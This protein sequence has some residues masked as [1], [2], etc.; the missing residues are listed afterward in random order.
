MKYPIGIQDFEKIIQDGYVYVDKTDL[1]YKLANEGHIYFLSRPRRFG[2]SL[3]ISTLK[4]YFQGRKDLFKGLAIDKLETKWAEYPVFH[5][6]FANGN[7]TEGKA[8]RQILEDYIAEIETVYGKNPNANTIGGRFA[9][10][11]KAAHKKT[12]RRAVVLIDEYDKP[13]LDVIDLDLKVTDSEG[14]RMRLE[15]Y[16][17]NLLKGFYSLFKDAD[18]DLQFVMLT[19]VTKF[20]QVSVFSGFNQPE[21]ISMSGDFEGLCGITKDELLSVFDEPI[22]ALADKFKIS[23]DETVERLKKKYDGYHFGEEMIDI[24]NPFSILNCL[25]S[26]RMH[27]F[28]FASGTPTYLVRLLAHS[29]ENINELV[30]K[31]YDASQFIDYKADIEQ[32]LPMIYQSGYL[33]I[34]DWN[35]D[36][37]TY[38]LDFPNEEV[39]N[40]FIETLASR[41][42]SESSQPKSWVND[43]TDAL[44]NGDTARFEKLMTALLSSTTYRF[45]RKQ[46]AMECE[47]YFQYTFYLIVKMLGFYSTVAEKETSEGRIDCV[48]ECPGYVYII[49]FKLNGSAEA[50]LKQI[51]EKGY[52][53]PYAADSRKL[54]AIGFNFSSEKGTIDGFLTKEL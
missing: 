44:D 23:Y 46:D 27:N 30:G 43:V 54:I 22:H 25:K 35:I 49:E 14:N 3:L 16:N 28:W 1:V 32:P 18:E 48:V 8:L 15:D 36:R 47:R 50:A 19:G 4:Y 6:S 34:K 17:R 29:N 45:Q 9:S 31:Y 20:S 51:E 2:K 38:L 52:A 12:G 42:F 11:L 5:L 33:T 26:K 37:N 41:Y 53:K 40:G 24:F 7:F 21:D 39:R 13:L 10:V